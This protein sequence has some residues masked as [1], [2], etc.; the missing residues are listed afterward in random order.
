LVILEFLFR[1]GQYDI[2]IVDEMTLFISVL[3]ALLS[4]ELHFILCSWILSDIL[5]HG[6]LLIII[7]KHL[8]V[9]QERHVPDELH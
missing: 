4:K 6:V 1:L 5:L 9:M 8:V 2:L 7:I 3:R